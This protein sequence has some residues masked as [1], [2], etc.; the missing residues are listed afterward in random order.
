MSNRGSSPRSASAFNRPRSD[1]E[2]QPAVEKTAHVQG[3]EDELRQKLSA[4][5]EIRLS[6]HIDLEARQAGIEQLGDKIFRI[7]AR[8]Q[9]IELRDGLIDTDAER[10][11]SA[12]RLRK[13]V[14]ARQG[15]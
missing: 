12:R 6:A 2:S 10:P 5:V 9:R 15:D 4:R 13:G 14:D 11:A 7:D 1:C 3:I 8:Q